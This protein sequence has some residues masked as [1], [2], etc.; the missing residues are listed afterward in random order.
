MEITA[1]GW[2]DGDPGG[3]MGN[4][5]C[6]VDVADVV[7]VHSNCSGD[8]WYQLFRNF[9]LSF[10][11]MLTGCLGISICLILVIPYMLYSQLG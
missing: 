4:T 10:L 3:R 6:D 9:V 5:S 2:K 1:T 8:L 7:Y 11:S